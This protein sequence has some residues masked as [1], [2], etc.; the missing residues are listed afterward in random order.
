MEDE[1]KLNP[2][3]NEEASQAPEESSTAETEQESTDSEVVENTES[4]VKDYKTQAENLTKALRA[5]REKNK[6][7]R[8]TV[9]KPAPAPVTTEDPAVQRFLKTEAN[10]TIAV[11]M[12]TDP[13]FKDR[14]EIVQS[15]VEQGYD[16][17]MADKLAKADIMEEILK[18]RTASTPVQPV[19]QMQPSA[20]PEPQAAFKSTGDSLS[21]FQKGAPI[22]G[23]SAAEA[24]ALRAV[25]NQYRP[26]Q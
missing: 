18:G 22:E 4:D 20:T 17:D 21:D 13:S 9:E 7:L 26:N 11:K 15:Y 8:E 12:Q 1:Y 10:A 5:E 14:V 16:I 25:V 24:A 19:T 3:E 23:L 2:D 6:R